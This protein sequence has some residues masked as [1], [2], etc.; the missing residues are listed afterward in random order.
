VDP[1]AASVAGGISKQEVWVMTRG[2]SIEE[3]HIGDAAEFSKRISEDDVRNFT[4]VTGDAAGTPGKP[5]TVPEMLCASLISTVLCAFLPG[6]GTRY[7]SQTLH[8]RQPVLVGDTIKARVTVTDKHEISNWLNL[9]T[10]CVN[11]K[12]DIVTDGEAIVMPPKY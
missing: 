8:F 5:A 4:G 1:Q 11:Q 2:K 9:K 7:L 3:I 10:V 12:G 6:S